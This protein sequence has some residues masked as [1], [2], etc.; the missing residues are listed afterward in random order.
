MIIN[1]FE[2]INSIHY[3]DEEVRIKQLLDWY[4]M[5][6]YQFPW[7]ENYTAY[8]VWISEIMLQQSQVNVVIPYYNQWMQKFPTIKHLSVSTL[9]QL[10]LL[11]Q[12]L[13]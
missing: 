7:R 12:G 9:D 13:G 5:Q 6:S 10:L 2:K 3:L 4:H 1:S 8:K 11:W